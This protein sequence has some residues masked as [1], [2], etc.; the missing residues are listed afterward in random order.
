MEFCRASMD[1]ENLGDNNIPTMEQKGDI[2]PTFL[3][4]NILIE[5]NEKGYWGGGRRQQQKRLCNTIPDMYKI[6]RKKPIK[7][8][9]QL[10]V[11]HQ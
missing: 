3:C 8:E 2:M 11:M 4:N 1:K 7:G 10:F 9:K 5:R 6:D